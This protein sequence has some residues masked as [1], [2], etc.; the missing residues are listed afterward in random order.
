MV[1]SAESGNETYWCQRFNG[2][3]YQGAGSWLSSKDR[4]IELTIRC[5]RDD[6]HLSY[7]PL[8]ASYPRC[9][10]GTVSD[11]LQ[12][13]LQDGTNPNKNC[14]PCVAGGNGTNPIH[15][16]LGT[17]LQTERDLDLGRG[18]GFT[19]YYTSGSYWAVS[20]LGLHWRHNFERRLTVIPGADGSTTLWAARPNGD[21]L[22]VVVSAAGVVS[23]DPDI[24]LQLS[25]VLDDA[26]Q[27]IGWRIE[28]L[29]QEVETYDTQGRLTELLIGR[30]Y[31]LR[32]NYDKQRLL[33]VV[34]DTGRQ[35]LLAYYDNGRISSVT[36]PDGTVIAYRY[37]IVGA[38]GADN[39]VDVTYAAGTASPQVKRYLYEDSRFPHSLTGMVDE[40]GNRYATWQYESSGR[41]VLSVHGSAEGSI[42]RVALTYNA[43]GTTTVV[44]ALAGARTFSYALS[45]GV[46]RFSGLSR[47]C[48]QCGGTSSSRTY[49]ASGNIDVDTDFVGTNTDY[50]TDGRG[51]VTRKI[52]S[53]NRPA[54]R[55]TTQTDWH[56]TFRAPIE[57]RT[58]D[59]NN[60]LLAKQIWTYNTRGQ[61]Q[62]ATQVDS[63]TGASRTTT[64]TYC[65]QADIDG[66]VCPLLGLV[67]SFDGPRT[68]V[69]DVT[70]Y[71]YRMI[72]EAS[73]ATSPTACRYR[74]G[75]L[76]KVTNSLG[77]VSET[78]RYDGAGRVLS[79]KDPNGVITDMEY[80]P[81]GWLTARKVRGADD[82][83]ESDDHI[84]RIEYEP[85]GLVKKTTLPDGSYTS[86]TYDAAHRLT[87]VID[88]EGNRIHYTLDNAGNKVKE[89]TIGHNGTVMR[90]LFRIYNQL[91]Q[92]QTAA[93]AHYN[94]TDFVYDA[95]GNTDIVIDAY[96]RIADNDYDPLNRLTRTIQDRG[97]INATT[98][99]EY[100]AQGNLTAVVD[101]KALA[102][103][104]TYNGLGDLTV[105]S[106][107]DT[108]TTT[109]TYD[110]AGNRKTQTDAR[111]EL[112]TY[113]Y[114]ALNRLT[115]I[116]YATTGLNVSYAY[117]LSHAVCDLD[118]RFPMGRLTALTDGSGTTQYCY[119]RFGQLTR[120]VQTTNGVAFT[121]RYAY[122]KA[123]QLSSLT[124]PDGTVVDYQRDALGR[125]TSVG[126]T[127]SGGARQ[128][129]LHQAVY[130]PFGPVAEWVFGNGRL[131]QRTLNQNY[132][133]GIVQDGFPGGLSVGYEFDAVGNLSTLR[134]GNQ[135]DPPQRRFGYDA[136]NRLTDAKDG[137]TG[138]LLQRYTYDA[139]GNRQSATVGALTTDYTIEANSH[140]LSA[141]GTVARGYNAAG[142]TTSIGGTA[143]QF[144]YD[145]AGR[146]SQVLRDNAVAMNYHYNGKGEQVHRSGGSVNTRIPSGRLPARKPDRGPPDDGKPD[147]SPFAAVDTYTMYD[148][149]GHW[150]GDYDSAGA[151]IQQ[152]IWVD[153]LPVGVIAD[154]KLHYIEA[155]H[156]GTPRVVLDPQRDVAVWSWELTG[157][158][159]G[160]STPNQDPDGDASA[161]VFNLRFPGQRYDAA[162]GLNYNYFRDYEAGTGRYTQSDP[163][164]QPGGLALYGYAYSNALIYDDYFGLAPN[165]RAEASYDGSYGM[166]SRTRRL[167]AGLKQS[168]FCVP[169][170]AISNPS[171]T[172]LIP[173]LRKFHMG[174]V[175]F[176]LPWAAGEWC[177]RTFTQRYNVERLRAMNVS[178]YEVCRDECGNEISRTLISQSKAEKWEH[179]SFETE[180][181]SEGWQYT[182]PPQ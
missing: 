160:N 149:A 59:A 147:R 37:Q 10:S 139:T 152:A 116:G 88:G 69:V 140:R 6:G 89:D 86:F 105:L 131:F 77:Q 103:R 118:E 19:R 24:H 133:P 57:R 28:N 181:W 106:S 71:T 169:V 138:G 65:E 132:Q 18:F 144:V 22:R 13:V 135:N 27:L 66:G 44:D 81:R 47:P 107:P 155:D 126:V 153:D 78:L 33:S 127:P 17:K 53:S 55:R 38:Y 1:A 64:T 31:T 35:L 170:P 51:L 102:T 39:L 46:K 122:T 68:D 23:K 96:G 45:H 54:T 121:L 34:D 41:A 16:A 29:E 43:D 173:D 145:A 7:I 21:L 179:A 166:T 32:L 92:L 56:P 119:N 178:N 50:D 5:R 20:G 100:D 101:P 15:G 84:T 25:R 134:N 114:D 128:V 108:G 176:G 76:W 110:S 113:D 93:D 63:G 75:D 83:S 158:A 104:Y 161:F 154:G 117:D 146:M 82:A 74:K 67:K 109:Y 48:A 42:D 95:N 165:C 148:E 125:T 163:I 4:Y 26:N 40:N 73:C 124:Y 87:D 168:R 182:P 164:G 80:H 172:D 171:P 85:T 12:C 58:F 180:S 159:F 14:S 150:L 11:G 72:D 141:V 157:E 129:L 112:T 61:T 91:G 60:A 123:G 115:A 151:P 99:F 130:Y 49:D 9:P 3:P 137:A 120:K 156:L 94:P 79:V 175:P 177:R 167:P 143:R 52:E 8:R 142:S 2:A 30:S 98:R 162:S 70:S 97:G 36:A 62:T 90:T 111:L 174:R 136:L